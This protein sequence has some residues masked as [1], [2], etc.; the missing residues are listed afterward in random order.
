VLEPRSRALSASTSVTILHSVLRFV[1]FFASLHFGAQSLNLDLK[2]CGLA[3]ELIP[4]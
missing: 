1:V 4:D 3:V 2:I